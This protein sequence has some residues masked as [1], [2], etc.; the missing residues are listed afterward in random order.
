[1]SRRRNEKIM[2]TFDE[3]L[4]GELKDPEFAAIWEAGEAEYQMRKAMIGVRY[5]LN[6]TQEEF[7]KAAGMRREVI[8][9]LESGN[10]NPTLKTL[11]RI[12]RAAGKRLEVR[13]V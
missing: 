6:M 12:A 5:E 4:A 8:T 13:F 2:G 9:R 7:A 3:H 11:A 10:G 1:M